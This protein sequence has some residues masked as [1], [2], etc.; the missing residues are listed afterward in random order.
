MNSPMTADASPAARFNVTTPLKAWNGGLS[1]LAL[2]GI[3]VL[4]CDHAVEGV[5]CTQEH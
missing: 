2:S 5:E 3:D 1:I 4:Q